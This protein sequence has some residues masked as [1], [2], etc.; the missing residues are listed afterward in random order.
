MALKV[1]VN[2]SLIRFINIVKKAGAT[3]VAAAVRVASR[4]T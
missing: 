4:Y 3:M 1:R 2:A